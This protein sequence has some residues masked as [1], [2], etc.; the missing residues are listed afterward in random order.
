MSDV[1]AQAGLSSSSAAL[2]PPETSAT[3]HGDLRRRTL[4]V[5]EAARVLGI[6]RSLAYECVRTG[7][8]PSLRLGTRIVVPAHV[9]DELLNA[10]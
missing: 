7:E 6:S 8:I 2:R 9:I 10:A 4:T 5:E 1:A 3:S